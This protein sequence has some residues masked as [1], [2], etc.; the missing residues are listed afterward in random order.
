MTVYLLDNSV[1]QRIGRTS[2]VARA[3][4]VLPGGRDL[5]AASEVTRLE[6]GYSATGATDHERVMRGIE[7]DFLYLPLSA[8]VGETAA[9]LQGMLFRAGMGRLAGLGDLLH[10]ATAIVHGA[11]VVHYDADYERMAEV[12]PRLRHHWIVPRGSV[13]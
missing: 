8:E 7:E 2:D 6:A 11:V 9:R 3:V 13:A 5:L 1:L 10:A 4:A 12:D